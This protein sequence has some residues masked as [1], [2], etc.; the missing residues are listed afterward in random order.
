MELVDVC[1]SASLAM[2]RHWRSVL[3]TD[4]VGLE[5]LGRPFFY[6]RAPVSSS[7]VQQACPAS[8]TGPAGCLGIYWICMTSCRRSHVTH[9]RSPSWQISPI[10]GD[11]G[12]GFGSNL[13]V[14]I[15]LW[16]FYT[17]GGCTG[18]SID[19]FAGWSDEF[20]C[21]AASSSVRWQP[22]VTCLVV[23]C[24]NSKCKPFRETPAF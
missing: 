23:I 24:I 2:Q 9:Q 6:S 7:R 14:Q 1:C 20:D 17:F 15:E 5:D 4:S 21:R 11:S 16:M 8:G 12:F 10:L 22:V 18:S 19:L 3:D 13:C